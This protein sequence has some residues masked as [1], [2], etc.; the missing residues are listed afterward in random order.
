MAAIESFA[1]RT[2]FQYRDEVPRPFLSGPLESAEQAA[3]PAALDPEFAGNPN[4]ARVIGGMNSQLPP[5]PS[6]QASE[7]EPSSTATGAVAPSI[8][9]LPTPVVDL[10]KF[11]KL[12]EWEGE[13]VSV[14]GNEF[15]AYLHDLTQE[16]PREEASFQ[17]DEVSEEDRTL[18]RT[19]AVFYWIIG[20]KTARGQRTTE[21]FLRFRRLPAWSKRDL[22]R[23]DERA[24]VL[25]NFLS[26][27]D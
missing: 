20:Y 19:G 25:R 27:G 26:G 2:A 16:S 12:Q 4:P 18:I 15:V 5:V 22:D 8:I 6:Q 1:Q 11:G 17:I 14:S 7:I 24:A 13:V 3:S 23:R 10:Q 21:S 9:R